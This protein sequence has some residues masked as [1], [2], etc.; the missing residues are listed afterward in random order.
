M[1]N[2]GDKLNLFEFQMKPVLILLLTAAIYCLVPTNVF[3]Q[4]YSI[5]T[6]AGYAFDDA[7]IYSGTS[8]EYDG[9]LKGGLIWGL[10]FE[11]IP[12]HSDY[13]LELM[14]LNR[15]TESPITSSSADT[16]GNQNLDIAMNYILFG[17]TKYF[18][19]DRSRKFYS[20][21]GAMLGVS[22]TNTDGSLT[23]GSVSS[24]N[25]AWGL[26]LGM[27]YLV[28]ESVGLNFNAQLLSTTQR[29]DEELFPGSASGT[30]GS[31]SS[32][33][34]GLNGGISFMFGDL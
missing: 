31:A 34:F 23:S 29:I 27:K 16:S 3:S 22:L 30:T 7:L 28:S 19:M 25:F 17:A 20:Y 5:N 9:L 26:R 11:Y 32:L 1:S 14:Y 8:A 21:T 15:A 33:Q 24:T 12:R 2:F 10:G 4:S 6:Y 18:K 13:G